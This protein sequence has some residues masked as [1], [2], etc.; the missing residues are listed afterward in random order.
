[1]I[2]K[3]RFKLFDFFANCEYFEEDYDYD[4]VLQ[5]PQEGSLVGGGEVPVVQEEL[6]IYNPDPLANITET[7]I[8]LEGMRVD[9]ELFQHF[10]RPI[11]ADREVVEAVKNEQWEHAIRLVQERYA[12]K[13]EDFVTLEKLTRAE[14]LDRRL[15]WKEVLQRAF[16]MIEVFKN[17]DALLEDEFKKFVAIH[18]PESGQVLVIKRLMKAYITDPRVRE[19][20]D[21]K[22]YAQLATNPSLSLDDLKIAGDWRDIVPEYI[23][24]YISLKPYL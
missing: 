12:N 5:L 10:T 14:Q 8:G 4:E 20:L 1:M 18:K 19:A 23:K 16:G 2:E 7:K 17:K 15:T 11:T 24:D 13:P 3:E 9:R 6:S 21:S 22:Q